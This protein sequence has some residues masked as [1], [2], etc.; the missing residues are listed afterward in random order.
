M[1]A[2]MVSP[3]LG[4]AILHVHEDLVVTSEAVAV[5][6]AVPRMTDGR[7]C[8]RGSSTDGKNDPLR[9]PRGRHLDSAALVFNCRSRTLLSVL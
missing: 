3:A 4:N 2:A 6:T 1:S 7:S 5:A 8:R 9:S